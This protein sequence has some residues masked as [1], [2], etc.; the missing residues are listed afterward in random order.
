MPDVFSKAKRSEVMS[1]IR[2]SGNRDTE[3]AMIRFLRSHRLSGWRR[4]QPVFG[5]PDFVFPR[6]R[7]AI[8][9]DG[10]FW[11][12]CP[13]H[14]TVPRNNQAFWKEK[15]RRNKSRDRVVLRTLRAS[16]WRVLRIWE[17]DLQPR[18]QKQLLLR[19]KRILS[20]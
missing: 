4:K 17:H 19:L 2:G 18:R 20:V 13:I 14:S 6:E 10:C 16:G 5:R 7:V 15:L 8:F 12:S 1:R 11:H 3:L 9:V